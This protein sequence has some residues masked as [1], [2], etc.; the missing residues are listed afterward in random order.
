MQK[1]ETELRLW[2]CKVCP[3]TS[4]WQ[5]YRGEIN[6]AEAHHT[7]A[8]YFHTKRKK[9]KGAGYFHSF[10]H[11][12]EGHWWVFLPLLA[13]KCSFNYQFGAESRKLFSSTVVTRKWKTSTSQAALIWSR[14]WSQ[15]HCLCR[16]VG[17]C[18]LMEPAD[19][20]GP[21]G[22]CCRDCPSS[23]ITLVCLLLSQQNSASTL[24][25]P[26]SL[27]S[28]CLPSGHLCLSRKP[29]HLRGIDFSAS[30]PQLS[31]WEHSKVLPAWFWCP[32]PRLAI[33]AWIRTFDS[34]RHRLFLY[35]T[36]PP[37]PHIA[38]QNLPWLPIAF[39]KGITLL[40]F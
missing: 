15:I 2:A 39:L 23:D 22:A 27:S 3:F 9:L 36:L 13:I 38:P 24:S 29:G 20:A 28:S 14:G 37:F 25:Q 17:L 32:G 11:F 34:G 40:H 33:T 10:F 35:T 7:L 1:C 18:V 6:R 12:L 21:D 16:R 19:G 5:K 26:F 4:P 30:D 31:S 8:S